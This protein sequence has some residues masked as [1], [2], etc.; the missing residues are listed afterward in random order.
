MDFLGVKAFGSPSRLEALL[1]S[2][3]DWG[4]YQHLLGEKK[5]KIR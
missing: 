1:I 4:P 5:P 2:G 3:K